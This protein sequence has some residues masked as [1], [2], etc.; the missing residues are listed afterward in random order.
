MVPSLQ[1]LIQKI[2]QLDRC[3][4][5]DPYKTCRYRSLLQIHLLL[6]LHMEVKN[7]VRKLPTLLFGE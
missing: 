2:P 1:R 5:S 3:R 7:E 6:L 4:Q